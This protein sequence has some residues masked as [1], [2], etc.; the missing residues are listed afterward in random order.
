MV[1]P[2]VCHSSP[3]KYAP[4]L[5]SEC[6]ICSL[7]ASNATVRAPSTDLKGSDLQESW[8][9]YH[10]SSNTAQIGFESRV[11]SKSW[12]SNIIGRSRIAKETELGESRMSYR[13]G[14][15]VFFSLS[16]MKELKTMCR[17]D[18]CLSKTISM[19]WFDSLVGT[20][21]PVTVDSPPCICWWVWGDNRQTSVYFK[22]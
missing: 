19:Q 10:T 1:T 2:S 9:K 7:R 21:V 6:N 13:W 22:W 3:Q 20:L 5:T 8:H 16:G 17:F 4:S 12:L 18:C 14:P 11:N 15:I